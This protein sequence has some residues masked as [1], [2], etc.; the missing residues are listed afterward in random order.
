M[1]IWQLD[2]VGS[3]S[4]VDGVAMVLWSLAVEQARLGHEVTLFVRTPLTEEGR[5]LAADEGFRVVEAP[6]TRRGVS[7]RVVR[8]ELRVQQ[9]DVVH[10][11]G[12]FYPTFAVAGF[13]LRR[14]RIP[15]VYSSHGALAPSV[16]LRRARLRAWYRKSIERPLAKGAAALIA[17]S[18]AEAAQM[19]ALVPGYAGEIA[20]VHPPVTPDV[21]TAPGWGGPGRE[22]PLLFLGRYQPFQKGLDRLAQLARAAPDLRFECHGVADE[23]DREAMAQV[24]DSA[25]PNITFGGPLYADEKLRSLAGASMMI[26]LSRSEGFPV[27]VAEAM[28][29]G[30][31]CAIAESVAGFSA[32]FTARRLGLV[33]PDDPE[34]AADCLRSALT[35]APSLREMAARAREYAIEGCSPHL[36]ARR[37]VAVY[38]GLVRF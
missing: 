4:S 21:L 3:P 10:L 34:T 14:R 6:R 19:R 27:S 25:P 13:L 7:T 15:Y 12:G 1:R 20:V 37:V 8:A 24:I 18:D 38:E 11:H 26:T 33:L 5:S 31:P 16:W 22:A 30:V 32:D 36:V 29:L 23:D 9:P 17:V 2:A 35:D 28:A